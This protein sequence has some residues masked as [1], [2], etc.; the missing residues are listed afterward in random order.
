MEWLLEVFLGFLLAVGSSTNPGEVGEM[1]GNVRVQERALLVLCFQFYVF[2]EA[3]VDFALDLLHDLL[4]LL[5]PQFHFPLCTALF[6]FSF[7]CLHWSS[8]LE[9][10]LFN[11]LEAQLIPYLMRCTMNHTLTLSREERRHGQGC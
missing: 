2:Y 10:R 9:P 3:L 5:N 1:N 4:F 8:Q 7:T 6:V 11:V